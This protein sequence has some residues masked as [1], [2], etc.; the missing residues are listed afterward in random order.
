M[1][2]HTSAQVCA[3]LRKS[4]VDYV[5]VVIKE[6][7]SVHEIAI[8]VTH[9]IARDFLVLDAFQLVKLSLQG[10]APIGGVVAIL[11]HSI[12]TLEL[13]FGEL[14]LDFR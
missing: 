1:E 6:T 11:V 10:V 14:P 12:A 7:A 2:F 5:P 3:S 4:I 13:G 9:E 8:L